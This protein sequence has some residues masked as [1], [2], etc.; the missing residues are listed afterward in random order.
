M[1][2]VL[3]VDGVSEVRSKARGWALYI[4]GW[5]AFYQS[6]ERRAVALFKELG[7]G[8]YSVEAQIVLANEIAVLG[9]EATALTLLE[10]A[11]ARGR[12]LESRDDIARA[13]CG[14]GRLA[15]RKGERVCAQAFYEEAVTILKQEMEIPDRVQWVLASCLEGMGE[16]ALAL[17]QASR[18]VRLLGRAEALRTSDR[19]RNMIGIEQPIYARLLAEARAQLGEEDFAA[20]WKEGYEM[21]TE[22]ALMVREPGER[23]ERITGSLPAL[24]PSGPATSASPPA[25]PAGLTR[26]EFEV[27]RLATQG[28]T[29]AQIAE[30]LVISLTTVSAYL[31]SIYSKL[32]VS[33]RLGAMRYAIDHHLF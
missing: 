17:R 16:I 24:S 3:S 19:Y 10:E 13:L 28:L 6:D 11:L 29:N 15:L 30:R 23:A 8:G 26:R 7:Y 2:R 33:S 4:V 32:G 21:T 31:S 12:V 9:D 5:L 20:L 27:L 22:R 25:P 14:L 1:E 18:A